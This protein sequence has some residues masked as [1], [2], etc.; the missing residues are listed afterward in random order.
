[1]GAVSFLILNHIIIQDDASYIFGN[2]GD[3]IV[4]GLII[5]FKAISNGL[6]TSFSGLISGIENA[7]GIPFSFWSTN[8]HTGYLLPVIFVVILGIALLIGIAF[9]DVMGYEKEVGEGISDITELE[10]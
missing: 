6:T 4:S 1:M 8:L 5:L 2:I 9:I 10:L 7:V 3:A